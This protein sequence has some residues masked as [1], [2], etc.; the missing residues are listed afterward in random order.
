MHVVA[1]HPLGLQLIVPRSCPLYWLMQ[2]ALP[3]NAMHMY[4]LC[5]LHKLLFCRSRLL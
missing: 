3:L 2:E 4:S 5:T 1:Q